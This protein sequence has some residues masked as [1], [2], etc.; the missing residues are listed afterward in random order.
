[1]SYQCQGCGKQVGLGV[2][3]TKVT[4]QSRKKVY[5]EHRSKPEGT[6]IV[7]QRGVCPECAIGNL[8]MM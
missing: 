7:E 5:T 2:K 3:M 6:E 1:M 4:I 8:E